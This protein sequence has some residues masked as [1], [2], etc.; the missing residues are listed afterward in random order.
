MPSVGTIRNTRACQSAEAIRSHWPDAP[1]TGIILGTG[2][3]GL[4]EEVEA[5][6]T[7][8]YAEIP[9]LPKTTALA[10]RGRLI[11][12]R[13]ANETTVVMDGRCHMYEG[14]SVDQITLPIRVLAE[15]GVQQLF[16]SNASGGLN[17]RYRSGDIVLLD[18]HID[19]TCRSWRIEN[20]RFDAP[21]PIANAGRYYDEDL[22]RRAL[23]IARRYDIS[24]HRGVYAGLT[25]PNYETRAEYRMLRRLGADVVGMSTVPEVV[26]AAALG[27][28]VMALSIVTNVAT[29]DCPTKT[30]AEQVVADAERA[31]KHLREIV[32]ALLR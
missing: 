16:I 27:I 8:P 22:L 21:R 30:S 3:G 18:D 17:P 6:A 24:A 32:T 14:Y 10:H 15:L 4:V 19:L 26:A 25:G 9:N 7:I 2:L 28:R 20:A 5:A 11:C 1:T 12:G 29:P 23:S 31:G 13:I